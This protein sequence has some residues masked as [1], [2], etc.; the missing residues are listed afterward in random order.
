MK[1]TSF[2]IVIAVFSL[3]A[4]LRW[5][6]ARRRRRLRESRRARRAERDR[7]WEETTGQH[8]SD[9]WRT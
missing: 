5:A 8:I 3:V 7:V 4:V 6:K 1:Q 2:L 9:D